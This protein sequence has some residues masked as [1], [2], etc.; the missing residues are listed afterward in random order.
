MMR[1]FREGQLVRI[2]ADFFSDNVL[3]DP[4]TIE[5]KVWS[6][7]STTEL[8]L[9]LADITKDATGQYSHQFTP[10]DIGIYTYRV[11]AGGTVIGAASRKFEVRD[12]RD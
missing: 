9:A 11:K 6:S 12:I 7:G 5:V 2:E 1:V 10:A 8:T 4:T 3:T